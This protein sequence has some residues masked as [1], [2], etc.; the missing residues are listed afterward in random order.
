MEA[1]EKV[2]TFESSVP[3]KS[4][5]GVRSYLESRNAAQPVGPVATSYGCSWTPT[6]AV[7]CDNQLNDWLFRHS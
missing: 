5:Q 2:P 1:M 4:A 7:A 3:S 6:L